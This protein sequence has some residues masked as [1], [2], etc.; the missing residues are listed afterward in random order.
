MAE[1]V[2]QQFKWAVER[3]REG[4]KKSDTAKVLW[5]K[6]SE[7]YSA[8]DAFAMEEFLTKY[9][10]VKGGGRLQKSDWDAM[11]SEDGASEQAAV[12][13]FADGKEDSEGTADGNFIA[14]RWV[15]LGRSSARAL[16]N[17]RARFLWV[18]LRHVSIG[19]YSHVSSGLCCGVYP[20]EGIRA[21][22]LG[23]A[24]ARIQWPFVVYFASSVG[25]REG[26]GLVAR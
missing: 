15:P 25:P 14:H 23:R 20:P 13:K 1:T 26:G 4:A 6:F 3:F 9:G 5:G 17:A 8:N 2:K 18:A 22:P 21:I 24:L 12:V 19:A 16:W 10:I 7:L 11:A